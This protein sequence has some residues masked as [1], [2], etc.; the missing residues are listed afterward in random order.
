MRATEMIAEISQLVNREIIGKDLIEKINSEFEDLQSKKTKLHSCSYLIWKNPMMTAGG[1]TF[2]S[3]MLKY[4]G[5]KNV[6][7]EQNRYPVIGFEDLQKA[8][9]EI[10]FLSSEP[11]PFK[12]KHKAEFSRELPNAKVFLVD[13]E[14]FSWYGS[15][16][17]KA[18]S[19]FKQLRE[20]IESAL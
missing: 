1:D 20:K 7:G 10:L 11:F 9:P 13:G 8:N 14:M 19:Y 12:E 2:I 17:L 3:E 18:A 16:L 15:R 5:Y 4:A 6:F